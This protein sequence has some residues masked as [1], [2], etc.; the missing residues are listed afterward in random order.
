M[1]LFSKILAVVILWW[2]ELIFIYPV[3]HEAGHALAA[4]ILQENVI[5]FDIFPIAFVTISDM[6]NSSVKT[7]V[8]LTGGI[9]FPMF[10]VVILRAGK[11]APWT[12]IA[13]LGIT[14]AYSLLHILYCLGLTT[15]L[16]RDDDIAVLLSICPDCKPAVLIISLI[17]FMLSIVI[18]FRSRFFHSLIQFLS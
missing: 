16:E 2:T 9:V 14:A 6:G 13:L 18:A 11:I 10:A 7:A 1:M 3:L 5:D 4:L 15:I 17:I 12:I 8:M